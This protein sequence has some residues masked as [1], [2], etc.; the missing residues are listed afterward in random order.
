MKRYISFLCGLMAISMFSCVGNKAAGENASVDAGTKVYV[1]KDSCQHLVVS[2]SLEVPTGN[3]SVSLQ[4]RDSLVADF[5]RCVSAPGIQEE[6]TTGVEPYKGDMSKIQD[7]VDY[8]GKAAYDSL[9]KMAL[10]DYEERT[11]FLEEDTTML[12]EDKERIK[13]DVPQ[14]AFD[15]DCKKT[16]DAESFTVYHSQIYCYYGGAHGGVTGTGAMTF[17]KATG[18]KIDRFINP[19]ATKALQPLIRKGLIAYYSEYGDTINDQQLSERLQ[20]EGTIIPQPRNTPY[21]NATGDS[22]TFT[23]GQYEIACYADGM[24]SFRLSVKDI[25][26]YLTPEAKASLNPTPAL[27]EREGEGHRLSE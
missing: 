12:E 25:E 10:A 8:Y 7:V 3:D 1:Y 11:A 22:L 20:I 13:N 24:P 19:D 23:Y 4:I 18:T 15:F 9:L 14:W 21:P 16:V 5:I 26:P 2:A 27:P 17:N 6:G